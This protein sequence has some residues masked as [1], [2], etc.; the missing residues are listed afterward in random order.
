MKVVVFD[1]SLAQFGHHI[2]FNRDLIELL[3]QDD[4]ELLYIDIEGIMSGAIPAGGAQI[5]PLT[6]RHLGG[7]GTRQ[8]TT[9]EFQ[10]LQGSITSFRRFWAFIE[11]LSP[12]IVI[13][14]SE[15]TRRKE[16]FG[17]IPDSLTDRTYAVVH[18]VWSI[19]SQLDGN[20]A[21]SE[22]YRNRLAGMF[23]LEPFLVDKL[24]NHGVRSFW[25][26]LRSYASYNA[27][28][29]RRPA[30]ST[31]LR[32]GSIGV[33][34]ERRNHKF[35]I[36]AL[37]DLEDLPFSFLLAGQLMPAVR[38]EILEAIEA[39][40]TDQRKS[41]KTEFEYLDDAKFDDA[42]SSLDLCI[43]AYDDS[44]DL[45]ASAAVY[46]FIEKGVPLLAPNTELFSFYGR[47]YPD[48]VKLYDAMDG[49][50]LRQAVRDFARD[51]A[52]R[53]RAITL[54]TQRAL[55]QNS[56]YDHRVYMHRLLSRLVTP[57]P[58][59][60]GAEFLDGAKH[61]LSMGRRV[62]A[63][64]YLLAGALLGD[65]RDE[66][67]A[68][69]MD[70]RRLV[71]DETGASHIATWRLEYDSDFAAEF[72][73]RP[74]DPTPFEIVVWPAFKSRSD[75]DDFLSRFAWHF[76]PIAAFI[77]KVHV[78]TDGDVGKPVEPS[79]LISRA[80]RKKRGY[81]LGKIFQRPA[82]AFASLKTEKTRFSLVWHYE[83]DEERRKPFP[84]SK[85]AAALYKKQIWRV[86][87][88]NERF[89]T[90]HFLKA[91]SDNIV[92][93]D[94]RVQSHA[95]FKRLAGKFSN[96]HVAVFGTGPSLSDAW[97]HDFSQ[98]DTIAANSMVKNIG[99][100]DHLKP[101]LIVCADP[102]FHAG[103][104]NYAEEFREHLRFAV[105]RYKCSLMV[106]ERDRHIYQDYY[107]G[108]DFDIISAPLTK[109]HLPNY[110]LTD[111]FTI[112]ST[113]N[114]LTLF[115]IQVGFSL[116][117][118]VDIY[119]CDGRP[120][121]E[122]SYFWSHD[123]S[124]QLNE[125]MT[126]IQRAHPGFFKISYDDYYDE[127]CATLERFLSQAETLGKSVVSKTFSYIPAL[128]SRQK[129]RSAA[130]TMTRTGIGT[131]LDP[132]AA[133]RL[134]AAQL[135]LDPVGALDRTRRDG[136]A[137]ALLRYAEGL[138][139]DDPLGRHF[140]KVWAFAQAR[141]P[142]DTADGISSASNG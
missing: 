19:I 85:T 95:S 62:A 124:A 70:L 54:G 83:N 47:H 68:W 111:D 135:L 20:P 125:H 90:S 110:A 73:N 16:V 13:A 88:E 52:T 35:I 65:A 141:H 34:N 89:A 120:P 118:Q 67:L 49:E 78:F 101:K 97:K 39:F 75:L 136:S 87:E 58:A 30:A 25:M 104:S 138:A 123:K 41:I 5:M 122:N 132:S 100:L 64:G 48:F 6:E 28:P 17:S 22:I 4:V 137:E 9:K 96:N 45:Q 43:L 59:L 77:S 117:Q 81:F 42:V 37:A 38:K 112:T 7:L 127:H 21:M 103:A 91:V 72:K 116:A 24:A 93:D 55:V 109:R 115:L 15:A 98:V 69:L 129:P 76:S 74:K 142:T 121:A 99:L 61:E 82:S 80:A 79:P 126:D 63:E 8:L 51:Y 12:D 86:D 106:P 36:D 56:L 2:H 14:A 71:N 92:I 114:I 105:K 11:S 66:T 29:A 60:A 140:R 102:I 108:D 46:S 26:P 31:T 139:P 130:E 23:V 84:E 27:E 44:R 40:P 18:P 53:N 119:G 50:A 10:E 128:V 94:Y 134:A 33:L 57:N 131:N 133:L 1:P 32:L 107:E 3:G 113:G